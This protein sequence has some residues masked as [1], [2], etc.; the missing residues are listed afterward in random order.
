[1]YLHRLH[2]N[3]RCR[4]VR[5][6]LS[7]PYQ[8]HATLCRAFSTVNEKCLKGEFLWRLE[9]EKDPSGCPRI[10]VQSRALPEWT[11]IGVK[12]WFA[13][14]QDP[15]LDLVS[16][17]RLDNLK[18]G[19]AFRFRLQANPC[20]TRDGKRL[21]LL[22]FPEQETWLHRKGMLHGFQIEAFQVSQEQMLRSKQHGGNPISIFSVLFDGRLA[23]TDPALFREVLRIGIG[24]GKALGL[25]LLSVV[26]VA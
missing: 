13:G 16:R 11:R 14:T 25:G 17:L 7:D 18:P 6:D 1:M 8:M 23:V 4:E 10:L 26:P 9:P 19:K 5:R 15:A 12:D 21:G 2:V 20:V 3:P 24:H 22:K